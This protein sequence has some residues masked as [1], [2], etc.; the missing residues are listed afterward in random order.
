[1]AAKFLTPNVWKVSLVS[2][3]TDISSEMLYPVLPLYMQ[4]IGLSGTVI[5]L[6]EGVAEG[7]AAWGKGY[8]GKL[9]DTEGKQ[10]KYIV[11]GYGLSALSKL[12]MGIS[13]FPLIIYIARLSDR[14]GKGIRSSPRDGLLGMEAN[15]TNAGKVFGFHRSLD[16]LGE[17]LDRAS[18]SHFYIS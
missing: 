17:Q 12:L 11:G 6:V 9:S 10:K 15:A 14:L 4:K 8:F 2:L 1:M 18:P 5:G 7:V 13:V 3:F 16:T